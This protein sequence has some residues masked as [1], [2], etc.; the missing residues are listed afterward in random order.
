[1]LFPPRAG[2]R[3]SFSVEK[4]S[5]PKLADGQVSMRAPV[6][7]HFCGSKLAG[8]LMQP[9]QPDMRLDIIRRELERLAETGCSRIQLAHIFE[10]TPQGVVSLDESGLSA[11]AWRQLSTAAS[12]LP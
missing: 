9:G 12:S 5:L 11:S 3:V 4:T 6:E 10:R 7:M 1:V 8:I 2:H